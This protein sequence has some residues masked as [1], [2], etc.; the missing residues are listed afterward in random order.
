MARQED[1]LYSPVD[2]PGGKPPEGAES[3]PQ[4]YW[5]V[6]E[7]KREDS[8]RTNY[9]RKLKGQLISEVDIGKESLGDAQAFI[10]E[11][12]AAEET[13]R[14]WGHR[15]LRA[16]HLIIERNGWESKPHGRNLASQ[17]VRTARETEEPHTVRHPDKVH[18]RLAHFIDVA[19]TMRTTEQP[20]M[21]TGHIGRAI[22]THHLGLHFAN[23]FGFGSGFIVYN[24][25]FEESVVRVIRDPNFTSIVIE[26]L[27]HP[28]EPLTIA[29]ELRN[30]RVGTSERFAS[31]DIVYDLQRRYNPPK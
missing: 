4:R 12:L 19:E 29:L 8:L 1:T 25:E 5:E 20:R 14:S 15:I 7:D 27:R 11:C 28:V 13:I 30:P 17:L 6:F 2:S 31:L 18:R 23:L 3:I 26:R 16:G 9:R 10:K 22:A 21:A 24:D